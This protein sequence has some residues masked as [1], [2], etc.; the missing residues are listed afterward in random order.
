MAVSRINHVGDAHVAYTGGGTY[1]N[2]IGSTITCNFDLRR[3]STIRLMVY[4]DSIAG[5]N[6]RFIVVDNWYQNLNAAYYLYATPTGYGSIRL[7]TSGD[8]I[9]LISA[10]ESS[11]YVA[12]VTVLD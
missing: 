9:S 4:A 1:Q 5:Y 8:T 2:D 11:L 10:T 12:T 7:E 3:F 6:R